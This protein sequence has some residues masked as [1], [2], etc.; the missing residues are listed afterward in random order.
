MT[1]IYGAASTSYKVD[2]P[3]MAA[4]ILGIALTLLAAI[5]ML[6]S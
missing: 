4:L 1:D 2:L 3:E 5:N 6:R